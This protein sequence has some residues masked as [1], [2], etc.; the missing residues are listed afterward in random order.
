MTDVETRAQGIIHYLHAGDVW[1]STERGS[2]T[3]TKG[4]GKS[5]LQR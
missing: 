1:D 3:R 4:W 5:S 2:V